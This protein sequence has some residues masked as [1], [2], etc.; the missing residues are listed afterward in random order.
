MDPVRVLKGERSMIL[1]IHQR[2]P[3]IMA[4]RSCLWGGKQIDPEPCVP[5]QT[6]N[7]IIN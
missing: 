6:G 1:Q 4:M 7:A 5:Q 2:G 3:W